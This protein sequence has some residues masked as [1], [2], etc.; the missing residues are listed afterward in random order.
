MMM[1]KLASP[2]DEVSD[3]TAQP[4]DV[5]RVHSSSER[6]TIKHA[7]EQ[8][9]TDLLGDFHAIPVHG[10]VRLAPFFPGHGFALMDPRG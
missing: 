7:S 10:I 6:L 8:Q 1:E 4:S 2:V 9:L 3:P 5:V